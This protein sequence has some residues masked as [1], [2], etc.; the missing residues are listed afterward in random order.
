M[1]KTLTRIREPQAP[2]AAPPAKRWRIRLGRVGL[3]LMVPVSVLG[4][5]EVGGTIG[6]ISTRL[7]PPPSRVAE[8]LVALGTGGDLWVHSLATTLRV[9]AGFALGAIVGSILGAA[10]GVSQRFLSLFDPTLQALRNIPSLAWTPLFIL[11]F[12]IFE[13]SKVL[14]IALGV[15]FPVYLTFSG[16]IAS[17]DRGLVE[18][19]KSY[20]F[21]TPT[22]IRRILFPASLPTYI[23]ALRNGLGMGWMFV[24]AAEFLGASEGLGYLQVDGQQTGRA[25]VIIASIV[26][27]ALL[28]KV[29]DR[30]LEAAGAKFTYWQDGFVREG[31]A[32]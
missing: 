18:V 6:W 10:S 4:L 11:W 22:L 12:G 28:G 26:M 16:A 23:L 3:G 7:V 31:A 21:S 27:F 14:M 30:V 15:F 19:G 29:T 17:V 5:W 25:N 9:L 20:G 32:R 8:T 13:T 1:T 24:I 2:G